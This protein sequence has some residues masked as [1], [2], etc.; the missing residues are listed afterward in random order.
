[1]QDA[2]GRAS[3]DLDL[4]DAEQGLKACRRSSHFTS[5][6]RLWSTSAVHFARTLGLPDGGAVQFET[7]RRSSEEYEEQEEEEEKQEE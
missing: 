4:E 6:R 1:M 7:G 5:R 3:R 2:Q